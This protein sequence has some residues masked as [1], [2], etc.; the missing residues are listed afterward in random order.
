MATSYSCYS[1]S[2][3]MMKNFKLIHQLSLSIS[4]SLNFSRLTSLT[5]FFPNFFSKNQN[6]LVYPHTQKS[7]LLQLTRKLNQNRKENTSYLFFEASWRHDTLAWCYNAHILSWA[8]FRCQGALGQCHNAEVLSKLV[9]QFLQGLWRR[10]PKASVV[11]LSLGLY[12]IFCD[13]TPQSSIVSH[14]ETNHSTPLHLQWQA[15][16]HAS[17]RSPTKVAHNFSFSIRTVF[18]NMFARFKL[19]RSSQAPTLHLLGPI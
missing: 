9:D 18:V 14:L 6:S 15:T 5:K 12:S 7:P 4:Q 13:C 1:S 3:M 17:G 19:P 2:T 16:S 8:N 11:M 10:A